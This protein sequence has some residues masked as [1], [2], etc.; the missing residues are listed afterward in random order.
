MKKEQTNEI[1]IIREAHFWIEIQKKYFSLC[2]KIYW[3]IVKFLM[4][5][6][7]EREQQ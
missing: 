7:C 5:W 3:N 1:A 4:Q 6:I 2:A